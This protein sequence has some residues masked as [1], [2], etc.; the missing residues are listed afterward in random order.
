MKKVLPVLVLMMISQMVYAIGDDSTYHRF[1][2]NWTK[3]RTW[4]KPYLQTIDTSIT[5]FQRYHPA[6]RDPYLRSTGNLG[7]PAYRLIPQLFEDIGLRIGITAYDVYNYK[8]ENVKFYNTRKPYS[9]LQYLMGS[10][11]EQMFQGTHTQNISKNYNVGFAFRRIGSDGLYKNMRTDYVNLLVHQSYHSNNDR[12]YIDFCAFRNKNSVRLNGG[13]TISID[14]LYSNPAFITKKVVPVRLDSAKYQYTENTIA[15]RQYVQLGKKY[16][17]KV[18]DTLTKNVLA[19]TSRIHHRFSYS[20]FRYLFTDDQR[21]FSYY[22]NIFLNTSKTRDSIYYE[23]LQNELRFE[24]TET[25]KR[26]DSVTLYRPFSFSIYG[27]HRLYRFITRSFENVQNLNAGFELSRHLPNTF[28]RSFRGYM[29]R[30][31]AYLSGEYSF[32]GYNKGEHQI[33][34][35][36]G[37]KLLGSYLYLMYHESRYMPSVIQQRYSGNHY[38]WDNTFSATTARRI[39]LYYTMFKSKIRLRYFYMMINNPV[40]FDAN[41][42]PAQLSGNINGSAFNMEVN[43]SLLKMHLDNYL[44]WQHYSVDILQYPKFF[45]VHS[46]YYANYLFK[47]A[48]QLQVGLDVFNNGTFHPYAFNINTSQFYLQ[49]NTTVTRYLWT[50]AFVNM[51][52]RSVRIT[53]KSDNVL[54][55]LFK[56]GADLI[57][58]WPLPDRTFKLM[59]NWMFWN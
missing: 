50:D 58:G 33:T 4:N 36:A 56:P 17:E 55:G 57:P 49:N 35:Y 52:I 16:K 34:A 23:T 51:K 59:I 18:N 39:S 29:N 37:N 26:L 9:E 8:T 22:P 28:D 40:Y 20:T 24:L 27:K 2:P 7:Y 10:G 54:Q 21:D 12:Y 11:N 19:V 3:Y 47:S 5:L 31:V 43:L 32:V 48:L 14:S 38:Q 42:R 6:M 15:I 44:T 46:F 53:I 1:D 45:S 41:A 13:L 30:T 25:K